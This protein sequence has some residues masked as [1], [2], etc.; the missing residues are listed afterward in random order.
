MGFFFGRRGIFEIDNMISL[1][2]VYHISVHQHPADRTN[3][4]A[5]L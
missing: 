1:G 5:N 3:M 2:Q 4:F